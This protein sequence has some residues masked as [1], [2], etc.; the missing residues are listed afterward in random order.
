VGVVLVGTLEGAEDVARAMEDASHAMK[1]GA[2][3]A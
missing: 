2:R 1:A 3:C